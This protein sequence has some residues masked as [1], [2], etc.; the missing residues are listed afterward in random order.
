MLIYILTTL[1]TRTRVRDVIRLSINISPVLA[2]PPGGWRE[3]LR[4]FL[5]VVGG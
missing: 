2:F 1:P 4:I 5:V 3:A